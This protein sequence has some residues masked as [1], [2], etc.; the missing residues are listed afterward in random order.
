MF[1][2]KKNKHKKFRDEKKNAVQD[3]LKEIEELI[4]QL[5]NSAQG[6]N[7]HC[8]DNID[9]DTIIDD[10]Q[11][12]KRI[13]KEQEFEDKRE[14]YE[15]EKYEKQKEQILNEASDR[16]KSMFENFQNNIA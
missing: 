7:M 4:G 8:I 9:D 13:Q 1:Q 6:A 11:L 2:K 5:S 12:E 15:A 10:E 3:L 16:D 14:K